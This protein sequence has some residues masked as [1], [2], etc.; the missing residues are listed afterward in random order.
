PCRF[1]G[2]SAGVARSSQPRAD[3]FNPF[4]IGGNT[5]HR[6]ELYL[7]FHRKQRGTKITLSESRTPDIESTRRS[8]FY[9]DNSG[10]F[11]VLR[12][13][14]GANPNLSAFLNAGYDGPVWVSN[15][16]KIGFLKPATRKI[17]SSSIRGAWFGVEKVIV[18]CSFRGSFWPSMHRRIGWR[19]LTRW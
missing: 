3:R 2:A 8:G 16:M 13:R 12:R 18:W 4:G 7:A 10:F 1:S 5:R 15:I 6:P 14:W 11:C 19:R 17:C 9:L